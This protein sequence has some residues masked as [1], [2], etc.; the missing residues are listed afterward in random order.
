[1]K[2]LLLILV[3]SALLIGCAFAANVSDFKVDKSVYTQSFNDTDGIIYSDAAQTSG[4]GIFKALDTTDDDD[5]DNDAGDNLI[6]NDGS[7]YLA[8]DDDYMLNKN[9][10]NIANFTDTDHGSHGMVEL[11]EVDNE[12]FV[13]VFWC[14]NAGDEVKLA[15]EVSEFNKENN[16][17]PIT[18]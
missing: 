2:K 4:I 15:S 7:D 1:M 5:N 17:T 18:F 6:M 3:M 10:D 9:S 12:Q 13:I 11:V 16:L 8:A 14:K